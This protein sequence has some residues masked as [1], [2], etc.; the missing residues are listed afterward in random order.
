MKNK[1]FNRGKKKPPTIILDISFNESRMSLEEE[2]ALEILKSKNNKR[3]D[4]FVYV[5]K[6]SFDTFYVWMVELKKGEE[7]SRYVVF[8]ENLS[9]YSAEYASVI[10][11]GSRSL[12]AKGF[13]FAKPIQFNFFR[14]NDILNWTIRIKE[15]KKKE[16][17]EEVEGSA[18]LV[19]KKKTK[20]PKETKKPSRWLWIFLIGVGI[21]FIL[22]L[23]TFV[24]DSDLSER[25]LKYSPI[26]SAMVNMIIIAVLAFVCINLGFSIYSRPIILSKFLASFSTGIDEDM[27]AFPKILNTLSDSKIDFRESKGGNEHVYDKYIYVS[28]SDYKIACDIVMKVYPSA[29]IMYGGDYLKQK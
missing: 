15:P 4:E 12:V 18:N 28:E 10:R 20:A 25:L 21:K 6:L 17:K 19:P 22:L 29:L 2:L 3:K 8:S 9:R 13:D 1:I 11:N 7:K 14:E 5:S 16:K 23:A 26:E 24:F 27:E